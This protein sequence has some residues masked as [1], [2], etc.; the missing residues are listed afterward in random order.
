MAERSR[1]LVNSLAKPTQLEVSASQLDGI[2]KALEDSVRFAGCRL[3][4]ATAV[5]LNLPQD[6]AAQCIIV[7]NRFWL[8]SEGGS[9][10]DYAVRVSIRPEMGIRHGIDCADD[11]T[12]DSVQDVAAASLSLVTKLSAVSQSARRILSVLNALSSEAST[13]SRV[14]ETGGL[15]ERASHHLPDTVY[16]ELRSRMHRQEVIL[17]RTIGFSIHAAVP[18]ALCLSY[19]Q[20]LG[21]FAHQ[22][23]QTLAKRTVAHL[24]GALLSPQTLF[25]THQ[26]NALAVAA[27]YLSAREVEVKLPELEWWKVFDVDRDELGFLVVT[28]Q[29]L[30]A[31]V[32]AQRYTWRDGTIP[33][34]VEGV[35]LESRRRSSALG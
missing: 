13:F 26:P 6:V 28:M 34:D 18:H 3:L 16:E 5:T 24:N 31:W 9:L 10:R 20:T 12:S 11:G 2:P 35:V 23:G 14:E 15:R 17:L 22:N 21:V 1:L 7:F 33:L 8:G 27:I 29:S 4:Q 30:E 19:L 32:Q 25:L